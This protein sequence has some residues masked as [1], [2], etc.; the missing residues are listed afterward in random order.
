MKH[1]LLLLNKACLIFEPNDPEYIRVSHRVYDYI[2]ETREY[3]ALYSTRFY[4]PMIFYLCWY[5]KLDNLIAYY[6]ENSSLTD[7]VRV[8]NLYLLLNDIDIQTINNING[9]SELDIIK[10]IS[11]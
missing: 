8:I 7:C 3:D 9:K 1:Y 11:F 2:N 4:G 6:I 10:V 5:K